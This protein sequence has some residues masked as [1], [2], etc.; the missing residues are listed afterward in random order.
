MVS[1]ANSKFGPSDLPPLLKV[2]E[3]AWMASISVRTLWRLVSARR[4]PDPVYIG[5]CARWRRSDVEAWIANS[6][7]TSQPDQ[8]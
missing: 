8:Q 3:A 1:F 7:R 4:F 2:G 5:R 6:C